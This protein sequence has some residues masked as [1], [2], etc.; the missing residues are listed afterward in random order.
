MKERFEKSSKIL[1]VEESGFS[2][3]FISKSPRIDGS[4]LY[5]DLYYIK[6]IKKKLLLYG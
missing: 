4:I 6:D 2:T 5:T 3:L 1:N